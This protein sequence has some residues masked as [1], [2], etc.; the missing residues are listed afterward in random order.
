MITHRM[1]QF[2]LLSG[3]GKKHLVD[4]LDERKKKLF[5]SVD[6]LR[7]RVPQFPD[8]IKVIVE[9]VIEELK[10]EQK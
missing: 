6:D 4:I 1:H 7:T 2:Q 5:E 8:P 10:D 9:R 3:V